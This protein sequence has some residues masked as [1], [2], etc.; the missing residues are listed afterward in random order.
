MK[1]LLAI[2]VLGLLWSTSGNA[3]HYQGHD[4]NKKSR[5]DRAF[6]SLGKMQ[7]NKRLRGIENRQYEL[8]EKQYQL[9]R[10]LA[11]EKI[12]NF[13]RERY[14]SDNRKFNNCKCGSLEKSDIGFNCKDGWRERNRKVAK[15]K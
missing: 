9:E 11:R 5:M 1:K 3:D 12:I 15:K 7:R 4:P 13:C 6:E 14:S 10:K 2:I 8:E